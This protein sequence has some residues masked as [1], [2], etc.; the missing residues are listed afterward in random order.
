M[1]VYVPKPAEA[2]AGPIGPGA[3][4]LMTEYL[5][6]MMLPTDPQRKMRMSL[7]LGQEVSWIRAAERVISGKIGGDPDLQGSVR[8]H[9]EDPNGETIDDDYEGDPRACEAYTLVKHPAKAL[10]DGQKQITVAE[11]QGQLWEITSRHMGLAGQG[12]WYLDQLNEL[13]IPTGILYIRPDRLWPDCDDQGNLI[14]WILD[15]KNI[16]NRSSGTPLKLREVIQ[17]PIETPSEGFLAEGLIESAVLKA[18]LNQ[19]IDRH[20]G[21]MVSSGGRLS[22]MFAPKGGQIDDD[23]TWDQLVRDF[24]NISEQ[25]DAAKRVQLMRGPMEYT[26]TQ[27]TFQEMAIVELMAKNRDDLLALWGVPLS[28]VGGSTATGLNSGDIRKYDEAALWQNAIVA[29]LVPIKQRIQRRLLDCWEPL[30]GWAPKLCL[31]IPEFDDDSPRYDKVAKAATV[32]LR[33]SERRGLLGFD[34]F[35]DDV[36]GPSGQRL[37][38]EVWV[39]TSVAPQAMAVAPEDG[40]GMMIVGAGAGGPVQD[41]AQQAMAM[42]TSGIPSQGPESPNMSLMSGM[43]A[44]VPAGGAGATLKAGPPKYVFGRPNPNYVAQTRSE[45]QSG[46]IPRAYTAQASRADI[47]NELNAIRQRAI[48]KTGKV[49]SPQ[50]ILATYR[51]NVERSHRPGIAARGQKRYG[52]QLTRQEVS[53]TWRADLSR[54]PLLANLLRVG[55]AS[56]DVTDAVLATLRKQWPEGSLDLVGKG[57]WTYDDKVPLSKVNADRRPG[58]RNPQIVEGVEAV[59]AVD[60]PTSPAVF[61]KTK[62]LGT[63]GLRPI[64]GWHKTKAYENAG[65]DTI[66]AY[67]G[68]GDAEWTQAVIDIADGISAPGKASLMDTIRELRQTLDAETTPGLMASVGLVLAQQKRDII[69]RL[70][71]QWDKIKQNPRDTTIWFPR[72][73]DTELE[74]ALRPMLQTVAERVNGHIKQEFPGKAK[75]VKRTAGA[76]EPAVETGIGTTVLRLA[77]QGAITHVLTRGAA[78]VTK[79]NDTTRQAIA[80]IVAQAIEDDLS[81]AEAGD[82]VAEWAGFDSYRAEMI[83]RTEMMDA[84]KAAALGSYDEIGVQ[85]VRAIDGTGDEECAARNGQIFPLDEADTTEDHPNGTLD[86][87]PLLGEEGKAAHV[88][89][90]TERVMEALTTASE[91]L[92]EV[93]KAK[94]TLVVPPDSIRV[95]VHVPEQPAPIVNVAAPKVPKPQVLIQQPPTPPRMRRVVDR[96]RSGKVIGMHEEEDD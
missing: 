14:R 11:N 69:T 2:K 64:D 38:D 86:W 77:P 9:L 85:Y 36:I 62:V 42:L 19:A 10:M 7:K 79:I 71:T 22:G 68:K 72:S 39:T 3:G 37:D 67:I 43:G 23:G 25:P 45:R 92:T 47:Q 28:Q 50:A 24:R 16:N 27:A 90:R 82:L 15:P 5:M 80:D 65:K 60:A 20:L 1:S 59:L 49:P 46:Q 8:W 12:Y 32:A 73:W 95:D 58:G 66:P 21:S 54:N 4:V 63:P 89:Q 53:S 40:N 56:N 34:P 96:D 81:P 78:R 75:P 41:E 52:R 74:S 84:Y 83:A 18:Q 13:G 44:S 93:A 70:R 48:D 91:A 33:N 29:R 57:D 76:A 31:D 30:L 94:L 17:F 87:E 6:P 35:G 51:R 26:R 88:E 61:V 55:K